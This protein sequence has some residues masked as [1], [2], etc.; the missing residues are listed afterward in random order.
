MDASKYRARLNQPGGSAFNPSVFK[1]TRYA[2]GFD[3]LPGPD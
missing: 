1:Q 3:E 2:P